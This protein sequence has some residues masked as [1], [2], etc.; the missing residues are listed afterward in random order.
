MYHKLIGIMCLVLVA[1]I[2]ITLLTQ[3]ESTE[4]QNSKS[5]TLVPLD[6]KNG[7]E[8]NIITQS[9]VNIDRITVSLT[10][11][12]PPGTSV[13]HAPEYLK[14]WSHKNMTYT[15]ITDRKYTKKS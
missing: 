10:P 3:V 7:E 6:I 8:Q 14:N 9:E 1:L 12:Y 13:G 11:S 15:P 4:S 5:Y 2:F